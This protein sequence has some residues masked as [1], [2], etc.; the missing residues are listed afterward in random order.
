MTFVPIATASLI[1]AASAVTATAQPVPAKA[2][3][4]PSAWSIS[5]DSGRG[6]AEIAATAKD[7]A[8][9]LILGCSKAGEPELAGVIAGYRGAG[10]RADGAVEPALLYASGEDWRDAFSIRLRYSAARRGW[11]L[12]H[13][14]SPLFLR[15]F[16]R[17]S[18]L[19]LVNSQNQDVLAFDLTGSTA[20]TRAMR[21]TCGLAD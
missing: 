2:P 10:L 4:A 18:S 13:P 8:G 7:G 9:R 21:T 20:A 5:A 17:G 12:A 19:V 14:L 15:S 11:E 16:S 3:G 1:V 6:A